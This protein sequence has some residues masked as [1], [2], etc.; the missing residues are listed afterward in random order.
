LISAIATITIIT[1]PSF[2]A[3]VVAASFAPVPFIIV[4]ASCALILVIHRLVVAAPLPQLAFVV[5]FFRHLSSSSRPFL[6][7]ASI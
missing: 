6:I 3:I 5:S 4:T 2:V 7:R 1:A